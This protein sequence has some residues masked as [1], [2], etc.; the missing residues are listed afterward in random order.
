MQGYGALG[1]VL[2]VALFIF[3][4][5]QGLNVLTPHYVESMRYRGVVVGTSTLVF[6][7]AASLSNLVI[8]FMPSGR[9]IRRGCLAASVLLG[10]PCF[11]FPLQHDAR[12]ILLLTA[13]RGVGLG[14]AGVLLSTA[15]ALVAPP[16]RRGLAIGLLGV[17]ATGVAAFAQAGD[18]FLADRFGFTV[19]F[20]TMGVVTL[21]GIPA[22]FALG[23]LPLNGGSFLGSRDDAFQWGVLLPSFLW[24]SV[25]ITYG[26]VLTFGPEMLSRIGAGVAV[27]Y[28]LVLA[29]VTAASRFASG[30][31]SDR[32][33]PGWM[34]GA[35]LLCAAAALA[36]LGSRH[37]W[38]VLILSAVLYGLCLGT[39]ATASQFTVLRR[40]HISR[41][42]LANGLFNF[43]GLSGLGIGGA[44]FGAVVDL[45]STRTMFLVT[46]SALVLGAAI[47][48]ADILLVR[49]GVT[50][51][52]HPLMLGS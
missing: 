3:A 52:E 4:S 32:F 12:S 37:S 42:N 24:F 10:I 31:L 8:G 6:M 51:S 21:V 28:F 11:V 38:S 23:Q 49:R 36:L 29:G 13:L 50:T 25:S 43:A 2:A 15:A 17:T 14:F 30:W 1:L 27:S 7:L 41:Y 40:V 44:L 16:G 45:T 18:L 26:A 39:V 48:T 5:Y 35:S 19:A 22:I 34:F 9:D 33:E 20:T 47:L 46:P